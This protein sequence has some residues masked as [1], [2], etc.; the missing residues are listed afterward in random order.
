MILVIH[1]VRNMILV[2]HQVRTMILVIHQDVYEQPDNQPPPPPRS[3]R[4]AVAPPSSKNTA[5]TRRPAEIPVNQQEEY[6][7]DP[8]ELP[9]APKPPIDDQPTYEDMG[10]EEQRNQKNNKHKAL[11]NRPGGK[12][13]PFT[14]ASRG[15]MATPDED[16][17]VD[18][19]EKPNQPTAPIPKR[20]PS[21]GKGSYPPEPSPREDL[22]G[23]MDMQTTESKDLIEDDIYVVPEEEEEKKK[24]SKAAAPP[25]VN[26]GKRD[27]PKTPASSA[28]QFRLPPRQQ[29][30]SSLPKPNKKELKKEPVVEKTPHRGLPPPPKG[31]GRPLPT[32]P[33]TSDQFED[34]DDELE[35][36]LNSYD[37]YRGTLTRQEG[38][39]KL[40]QNHQNG[41]FA[42]RD[43]SKKAADGDPRP[44]TLMIFNDNKVYNLPIRKR[45][46]DGHY[47]MG[48]PKPREETFPK[49]ADLVAFFSKRMI[50]LA[51]SGQTHL[52]MPLP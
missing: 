37:W 45:V 2:I 16:S 42:I 41:M 1:Q 38:D 3:G 10:E 11:P 49:L 15:R 46:A 4:R 21:Q 22:P 29:D 13:K 26:R 19:Y 23:Y 27:L 17:D 33:Q 12:S 14:S 35:E 7:E 48:N 28:P 43:S 50:V 25:P 9:E 31:G 32:V 6:Y 18:D 44:Y 34:E 39:T 30:S 20:F 5:G 36:D 51:G 52:K 8:S 47:A 40:K 24:P